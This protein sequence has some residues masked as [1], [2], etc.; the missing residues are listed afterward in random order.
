MGLSLEQLKELEEIIHKATAYIP[1]RVQ[2]ALGG[3]PAAEPFKQ[4]A[5]I[6][7]I[8]FRDAIDDALYAKQSALEEE[9]RQAELARTEIDREGWT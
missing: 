3:G 5:E 8:A 9:E 7:G 2:G 1:A 4:M 6:I